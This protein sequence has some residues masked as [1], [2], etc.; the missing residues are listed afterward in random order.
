[1]DPPPLVSGAAVTKHAGLVGLKQQKCALT[2]LECTSGVEAGLRPSMAPPA[3]RVCST[4]PSWLLVVTGDLQEHRC[5]VSLPVTQPSPWCVCVSVSPPYRVTSHTG[6][7]PRYSVRPHVNQ[8]HPGKCVS[9]M[10]TALPACHHH[11]HC[12]VRATRV[13]ET[14]VSRTSSKTTLT[15]QQLY[16]SK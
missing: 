5:Q 9:C 8:L 15:K 2:V 4:L 3:L 7:S 1:M 14:L 10:G 6:L 12:T 11:Q 16:V 13:G